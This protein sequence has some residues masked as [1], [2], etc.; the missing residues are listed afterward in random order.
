MVDDDDGDEF[1]SPEPR[2]DSRSALPREIRAWRRFRIVKRDD[3][4]SLIF[5]LPES[6]YMELELASEGHQG[7][8]EV[9]V[10]PRGSPHPREQGVGPLIFIFCKDFLLFFL[11]CS[12]E[13]QVILRTSIFCT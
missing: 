6:Q 11:R 2:T 1:P 5:I 10:A 4:F 9:G 8:H 12:M 7:A 13:F 3:F